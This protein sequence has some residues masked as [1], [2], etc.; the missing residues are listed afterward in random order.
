MGSPPEKWLTDTGA[1]YH[2][3]GKNDLVPGDARSW[4]LAQK[5]STPV[6]VLTA[7]G[8]TT[9]KHELPIQSGVLEDTIF[10]C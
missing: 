3:T 5:T 6:Q 8:L 10:P 4:A 1:R 9:V 7:N 2:M